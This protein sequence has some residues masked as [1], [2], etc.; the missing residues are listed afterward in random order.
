MSRMTTPPPF[1]K[2]QPGNVGVEFGRLA[3]YFPQ[4]NTQSW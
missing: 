2:H 1:I 4:H 3:G